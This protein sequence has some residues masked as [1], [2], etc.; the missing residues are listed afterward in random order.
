MNKYEEKL[1][2]ISKMEVFIQENFSSKLL[3]KDKL[4]GK[5]CWWLNVL[6]VPTNN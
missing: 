6:F 3:A 5:W 1:D 4:Q 2:L